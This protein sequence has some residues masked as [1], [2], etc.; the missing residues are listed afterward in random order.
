MSANSFPFKRQAD[1][2]ILTVATTATQYN[3]DP[4]FFV[5]G[6]GK[7]ATQFM[8]YNPNLFPVRLKGSGNGYLGTGSYA[9]VA[10]DTGWCFPP[11]ISGPFTTQIPRYMSTLAVPGLG[12]SAGTGII[13]LSYGTGS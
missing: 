4:A 11:G 5:S 3:V 6:A 2:L 9:A 13:E 12:Q 10:S 7:G 1:P 8:V